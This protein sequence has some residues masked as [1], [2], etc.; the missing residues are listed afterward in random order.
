MGIWCQ[1]CVVAGGCA[2]YETRPEE[3]RTFNCGYLMEPALGPEWKPSDS[4]I[5]LLTEEKGR[6]ILAHVDKQ[7]PDSW[8]REPFYSALKQ[9]AS[10]GRASG[11]QVMVAIGHRRIAILADRDVELTE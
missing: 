8:K 4:K 5:V 10:D 9:W 11:M 2:I 1:H 3:C 6:R 7:R